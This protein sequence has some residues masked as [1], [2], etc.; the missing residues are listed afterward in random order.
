MSFTSSF[1]SGGFDLG[2]GM[3]E[4]FKTLSGYVCH[5]LFSVSKNGFGTR[6][7]ANIWKL[8]ERYQVFT[9]KLPQLRHRSCTSN[10]EPTGG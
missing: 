4:E 5:K 1:G 2:N 3:R 9:K 6:R 8:S 7:I 10:G